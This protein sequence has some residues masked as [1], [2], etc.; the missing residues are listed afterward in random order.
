MSVRIFFSLP[1][2]SLLDIGAVETV[3]NVFKTLEVL[4]TKYET[5]TL[6]LQGKVIGT[7]WKNLL[8]PLRENVG[9]KLAPFSRLCTTA[10]DDVFPSLAVST[11]LCSELEN[12]I[13]EISEAY[14]LFTFSVW[15]LL[16]HLA[17]AS[18]R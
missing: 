12:S 10:L 9:F 4:C 17:P 5:S 16:A 18:T 7:Q 1:D 14:P 11:R 8:Q 2:V 13:L 15:R 3:A 6:P